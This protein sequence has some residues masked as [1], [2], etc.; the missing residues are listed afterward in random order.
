M[1]RKK[2]QY[3]RS[4]YGKQNPHWPICLTLMINY[5]ISG[6]QLF[7][8]IVNDQTIFPKSLNFGLKYEVLNNSFNMRVINC[9]FIWV[10]LCFVYFVHKPPI[11]QF[12]S[13]IQQC[14]LIFHVRYK[15]KFYNLS[16][17]NGNQVQK[18]K[19]FGQ[20]R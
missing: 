7:F 16:P 11:T 14:H 8:T 10:S 6:C 20:N 13:Q 19:I 1:F 9:L 4:V 3:N 2:Y 15:P 5:F 17:W 12:T 18:C